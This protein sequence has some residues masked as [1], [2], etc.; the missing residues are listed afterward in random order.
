LAISLNS[1][2][3]VDFVDKDIESLLTDMIRDYEL[4]YFEQT[5]QE[6]VLQQGDPIRI[7]IYSQALRIYTAYQLID[8]SAKMNLLK[9]SEGNYLDHIGSRIGVTRL[10]SSFATATVQ[11]TLSSIQQDSILIPKGTRI[12]TG[13]NIYFATMAVAEITSGS[14][15][16]DVQVECLESG[17]VGNGFTPGQINT[18]VEPIAYIEKAEN[19]DE[20]K[21]G[22][23]IEDDERL[24]ERIY[25]AP[26]SFSVAGPTGAYEFFA[27]EYSSSIEDVKVTSPSPGEVDIRII[28]KD[29]EIPSDTIINGVNDYLSDKT[30]RP[31]TDN[32]TVQAPTQ[33]QYNLNATYYL[34]DADE[35]FASSIQ[36]EVTKAI[37]DYI[38]WQKSKIGRDINPSELTLRMIQAGA[39]RVVITEPIFTQLQDTDIAVDNTINIVYGGLENE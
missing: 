22:T 9:Y 4:A 34:R 26:E 37:S 10:E 3:D 36:L 27:K 30:R 19:I 13:N 33:I 23:D 8:R 35:N 21:G 5:G 29:G 16:I 31:L 20:S 6:K 1:L 12:S 32:V 24:R 17:I 38:V 2:P 14:S 15:T 11:F 39:K 25:L 18:L 28:L 7:W